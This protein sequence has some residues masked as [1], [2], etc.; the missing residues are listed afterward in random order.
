MA[1]FRT[2]STDYR[3]VRTDLGYALVLPHK[4]YD[5]FDQRILGLGRVDQRTEPFDAICAVFDLEGFTTFCSGIDPELT[6]PAFM[7]DF[8]SWLFVRIKDETTAQ[9]GLAT[10]V[11]LFNPLPLFAKFMGDGVMLLWDATRLNDNAAFNIA[12]TAANICYAYKNTYAPD[13]RKEFSNAPKRLRAGVARGRV[14]PIG[15]GSDFV[16]PSI[17][18]AAR[19]QKIVPGVSWCMSKRGFSIKAC[20]A[21]ARARLVLKEVSVRGVGSGELVYV[22]L[23][24]YAEV[25][26]QDRSAFRDV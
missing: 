11:V 10:G 20:D 5:R 9:S 22:A 19:L 1:R 14:I 4:V 3:N 2:R 6:V 26:E 15:N 23:S 18:L 25:K 7:S 8:L 12:L 21:A 24:E 13:A 16:G 17:N